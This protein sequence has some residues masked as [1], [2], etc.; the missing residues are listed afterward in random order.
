MG[1]IHLSANFGVLSKYFYLTP[2]K[3]IS[4]LKSWKK[5]IDPDNP[6]LF[7]CTV[8]TRKNI[9]PWLPGLLAVLFMAAGYISHAQTRSLDSLLSI[10]HRHPKRDSAKVALIMQYV[11]IAVN[12]N[13]TRLLPLLNEE[14]SISKQ[15]GFRRGLQSGYITGQM[16]YADRG[17]IATSLL[18]ADSAFEIGKG[19]TSIQGQRNTAY[20][21]HNVAGDYYKIGA[22]DDAIR[23]YNQAAVFF[24][25]YEPQNLSGVYNGIAMVYENM[26]SLSKSREYFE[27]ALDAARQYGDEVRVAKAY[28]GYITWFINRNKTDTAALLLHKVKPIVLKAN[29]AICTFLYYQSRGNIAHMRKQYAAAIEDYKKTYRITVEADDVYRQVN[30][31]NPLCKALIEAGKMQEAKDYI[32][33]LS[34]L[35]EKHDFAFGKLHALS[36]YAEWYEKKE[37][38]K[39][40]G[41]YLKKKLVLSDSISGSNLQEK[42]A[43]LETRFKV[44]NKDN[45]I[46]M[47]TDEKRIRE[48]SLRQKNI[49]NYVLIGSAAA[50]LVI[51]ILGYRNYTHHRKLQQQII[52]ELETQQ[53]LTATEAVLK[54]ES[55]ERTRL[56]KDLHDGLGGMLSGIKY[57]L[58]TMK[59]NLIMTPENARAFEKS[60]DMLDSSIQEMRRVAHNMM[61][62]ALVKFGLDTALKDFCLSISQSGALTVLYQSIGLNKMSPEQ[63]VAVTIYRIVQELITNAIRHADATQAIVQLSVTDGTLSITVEDNGK[64][65]DTT[66]LNESAGMGWGNIKNRVHFLNGALDIQSARDKGTSVLIELPLT[67]L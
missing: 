6:F 38:Y 50:L 14:I 58:N 35:S 61:P 40:A 44:E 16:Y 39:T 49:L 24:A 21:H 19:D 53:Q 62:E 43:S 22:Y 46:K 55:R 64:G 15:I 13:T 56:A 25:K 63:T 34:S 4:S 3:I 59:G 10:I 52:A 11:K 54:G 66:A 36:N 20:L 51:L 60:I 57:S 33:T 27:K 5:R 65:F 18:Y 31:L 48:L 67:L 1:I 37:D 23:H 7:I 26:E 41:L 29:D 8:N 17:D 32:D 28:L 12:E 47:L 42:I 2:G 45:E 30:I 9:R